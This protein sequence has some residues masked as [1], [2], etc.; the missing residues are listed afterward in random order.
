ML[1]TLFLCKIPL[2]GR[3]GL[4]GQLC[5]MKSSGTQSS[6]SSLCFLPVSFQVKTFQGAKKNE[7]KESQS[8]LMQEV[9]RSS[10]KDRTFPCTYFCPEL[11]HMVTS[12]CKGG[13]KIYF[14]CEW[15]CS[16]IKTLLLWRRNRYQGKAVKLLVSIALCSSCKSLL[17]DVLLFH[18]VPV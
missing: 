6:S 1:E 12:N 13:W 11:H 3:P 7:N 16:Q 4:T 10:H 18:K 2:P 15:P 9:L 8:C 17:S 5:S 14:L